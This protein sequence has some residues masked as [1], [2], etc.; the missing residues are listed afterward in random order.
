MK[1]RVLAV[2]MC[3]LMAGTAFTGFKDAGDD[4]EL[5]LFTWE[6]MFPQEVLDDFEKETGVKVVYS[7]FD[8]DE[9]MLEKLS[10]AKGGDYDIVIADDYILETA[11]QEGLAEA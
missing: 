10:M 4:K 9:T 8:T 1:K 11:I 7:N 5:V 3:A 6:G 2:V